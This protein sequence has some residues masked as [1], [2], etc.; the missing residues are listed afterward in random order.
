MSARKR[1]G[2]S[3]HHCPGCDGYDCGGMSPTELELVRAEIK[4]EAVYENYV[5]RPDDKFPARIVLGE[6]WPVPLDTSSSGEP[7]SNRYCAIGLD[8]KRRYRSKQRIVSDEQ[9]ELFGD[10]DCPSYRLVLE[11]ICDA[12]EKVE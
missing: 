9:V 1:G 4:K 5:V 12:R 10:E 6:G 7:I 2:N 3:D 8:A 11:R